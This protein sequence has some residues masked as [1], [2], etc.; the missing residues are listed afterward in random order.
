MAYE[1]IR[2]HIYGSKGVKPLKPIK[3]T[4]TTKKGVMFYCFTEFFFNSNTL[5]LDSLDFDFKYACIVILF[6]DKF[7]FYW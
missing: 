4:S 5:N 6:Q 2:G 7:F 1:P 3:Y